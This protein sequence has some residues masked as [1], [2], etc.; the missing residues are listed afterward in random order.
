MR[1][2]LVVVA[3]PGLQ[4]RPSVT[5]GAEQRLVEQLVAQAAV[6]ALVVAVLLRLAGRDLAPADLHVVGP[7]QDG[8]GGQLRAVVAGPRTGSEDLLRAA[9]AAHDGVELAGHAEPGERGV[10]HQRHALAGAVVDDGEDAEAPAVGHLVG[11]EVQAPALVGLQWDL[12]RP[13]RAHG[14]LRPPRRRTVSFS[15]RVVALHALAVHRVT[16]AAEQ[17]MQA[18]VAEPAPLRRQ[19]LQPLAQ[20]VSP[21]RVAW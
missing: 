1:P 8:V 13:P 21:G 9:P 20:P 18:S 15:S 5:E 17:D 14:R 6:E 4:H 3:P 19:R 7:A 12:D 2:L 10:G 11:D 16:F